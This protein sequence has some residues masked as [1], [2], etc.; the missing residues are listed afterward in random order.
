MKTLKFK[1]VH[2]WTPGV[3]VDRKRYQRDLS[4][5]GNV[6]GHAQ[7]TSITG[8]VANLIV[9]PVFD[10]ISTSG[11]YLMLFSEVAQCRYRWK[12]IGRALKHCR[13]R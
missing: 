4:G 2:G 7:S 13:S 11:L 12:W 5:C 6:F 3:V 1:M 9:L 8:I 10:T